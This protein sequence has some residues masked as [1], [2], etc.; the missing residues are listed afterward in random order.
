MFAS[1]F[2]AWNRWISA[3]GL[4]AAF[5]ASSSCSGRA[6]LSDSNEVVRSS[7]QVSMHLHSRPPAIASLAQSADRLHPTE[8]FLH[9]LAYPLTE[10]VARIADSARVERRTS[11]ARMI[12]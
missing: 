3:Q 5:S 11:W 10:R 4:E 7:N 12:L 6:E 2:S 8:S 1:R 9:L